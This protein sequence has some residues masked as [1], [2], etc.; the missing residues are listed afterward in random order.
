M[1]GGR[2]LKFK[3]VQDLEDQ[4]KQYF[5]NCDS[6]EEPYT[7]TGLAVALDTSRETLC[8]YE[9][10]EEY[11]DTIKRA[12]DKCEKY[13]EINALKGKLNPAFSIFNLKNNYGWKDK[14]ESEVYGKNGPLEFVIRN[15]KDGDNSAL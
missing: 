14:N 3:T 6:I 10:R 9:E 7:I 13:L 2:P 5:K 8:N 4:I 12:K 15:P 11:F 1:P